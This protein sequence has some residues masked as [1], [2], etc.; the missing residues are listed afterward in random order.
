M[1]VKVR[2]AHRKNTTEDLVFK[3]KYSK[4]LL[5]KPEKV[6]ISCVKKKNASTVTDSKF[7]FTFLFV[8]ILKIFAVYLTLRYEGFLLILFYFFYLIPQFLLNIL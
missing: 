2:A 7:S 5:L 6:N 1:S 4:R 8:L 3:L